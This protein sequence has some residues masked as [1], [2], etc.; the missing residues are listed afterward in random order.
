MPENAGSQT[1]LSTK[2]SAIGPVPVSIVDRSGAEVVH[3]DITTW[4]TPP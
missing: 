2:S 4:V 1:R 3:A